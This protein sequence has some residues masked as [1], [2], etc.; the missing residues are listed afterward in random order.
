MLALKYWIL[1]ILTL[2]HNFNTNGNAPKNDFYLNFCLWRSGRKSEWHGNLFLGI[3]KEYLQDVRLRE[4]EDKLPEIRSIKLM[5]RKE[6][7][8]GR[9]AGQADDTEGRMI[10]GA[11][12]LFHTYPCCSRS[13]QIHTPGREQ[14]YCWLGTLE[15]ACASTHV[16][17]FEQGSQMPKAGQLD[18]NFN[19]PVR[20]G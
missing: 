13:W 1:C 19:L 2:K 14:T 8:K 7:E 9:V 16:L 4:A 10:H 17:Q 6:E 5:G 12:W 20:L 18:A 11:P 15:G 3:P